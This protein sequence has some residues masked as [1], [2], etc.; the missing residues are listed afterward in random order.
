M[1][2]KPDQRKDESGVFLCVLVQFPVGRHKP[3]V[4]GD[5]SGV[6]LPLTNAAWSS[7]TDI[8]PLLSRST[9]ENHW[10]SSWFAPLGGAGGGGA[11]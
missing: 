7:V 6:C 3:R 8:C 4:S 5:R 1:K 2:I 11:C 9:V 10:Y